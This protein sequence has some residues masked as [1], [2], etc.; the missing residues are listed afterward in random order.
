[1]GT[2]DGETATLVDWLNR[3]EDKLD[4]VIQNVLPR[5]AALETNVAALLA[6]PARFRAWS[7]WA[8]GLVMAAMGCFGCVGTLSSLVGIASFI[9]VLVTRLR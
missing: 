4:N 6:A 8:I 1:M 9:L 7:S 2:T 3:L 5:V